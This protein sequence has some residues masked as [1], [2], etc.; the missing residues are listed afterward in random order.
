MSTKNF[1]AGF[2]QG[3]YWLRHWAQLQHSEDDSSMSLARDVGSL[4][5]LFPWM[6][7]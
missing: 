4:F 5:F 7:F 2:I 1:Y 6:A 3:M